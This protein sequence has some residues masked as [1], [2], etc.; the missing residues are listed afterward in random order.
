MYYHIFLLVLNAYFLGEET[1]KAFLV[2]DIIIILFA[3]ITS[4]YLTQTYNTL[5]TSTSVFSVFIDDIPNTSTFILRLP[6]IVGTLGALIL[7]VSYSGI[8]RRRQG[9]LN[10]SNF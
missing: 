3:F 8:R 1:P 7:I 2:I 10:V 4:V 9:G 5:I 6:Q